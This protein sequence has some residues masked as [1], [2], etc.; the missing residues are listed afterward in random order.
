VSNLA[1]STTCPAARL[2]HLG[3]GAGDG[4]GQEFVGQAHGV[5]QRERARRQRAVIT[6]AHRSVLG[7]IVACIRQQQKKFVAASTHHRVAGARMLLQKMSNLDQHLIA[8]FVAVGI[9]D[10]LEMIKVNIDHRPALRFAVPAL[11]HRKVPAVETAGQ[12]VLQALLAQRLGLLHLIGHV[13]GVPDNVGM[14]RHLG[15]EARAVSPAPRG[16]APMAN[17]HQPFI[18]FAAL[19]AQQVLGKGDLVSV[20]DKICERL[21]NQLVLALAEGFCNGWIGHQQAPFEVVQKNIAA[22]QT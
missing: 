12:L 7:E 16:T 14:L 18:V 4:V 3:I 19:H 2:V 9:V 10:A 6:Q 11:E 13:H 21:A 15:V 22:T 5:A 8:T 17:I 1:D 20:S